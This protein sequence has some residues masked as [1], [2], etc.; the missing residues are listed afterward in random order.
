M[1]GRSL[2]IKAVSSSQP[3]DSGSQVVFCDFD[4]PIVD[5]SERYYR[6]Y[7]QGLLAIAAFCQREKNVC[8]AIAP[9]SKSQFWQ[10]KQH[11]V[12]D[13]EIALH[14]GVPAEWFEP[15]IQQ[16]ER[17]V[18]HTSLLRWDQI[19]PSAKSALLYLKQSRMRLVLV[20]LRHPR[21][22][23]AFL[24][25]QAIAHLIDD[26]YGASTVSAAHENRIDHK[27][28]LLA[29]AI[30]QQNSKGY[31]TTHSWMIGDTEADVLAAKAMGLPS[32]ALACGIRSSDYLRSLEP[33]EMY[34]ELHSA[35]RAIVA[36][37]RLQV[38]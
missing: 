13:S 34:S 7:R 30:E 38:A 29:T 18:N 33:T 32:A 4:G 6:T 22:V 9:L 5:V 24:Q 25:E 19:Q 11:R 28:K 10:K 21:Q 16:V 23:N 26:V 35:A 37:S 2:L 31:G 15:Y 12:A 3:E 14:S 27:C 20:T 17:I 1:P 8:L 36:T